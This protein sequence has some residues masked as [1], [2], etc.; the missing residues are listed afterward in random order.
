M[1]LVLGLLLPARPS[2]CD[3]EAPRW[4]ESAEVTLGPVERGHQTVSVRLSPGVTRSYDRLRIE[5]V[6]RQQFEWTDSAGKV[7]T[8]VHEPVRFAHER[9]TVR[10]TQDLDLHVSFR[11]PIDV[12]LLRERYG[13]ST[14]RPDVAVQVPRVRLLALEGGK[15][16]WAYDVPTSGGAHELDVPTPLRPGSPPA[17]GRTAL[18]QVNLD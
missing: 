17:G 15:T 7:R 18:G 3:E 9:E 2:R 13:T 6:Y 16:L 14:F 5:C 11:M 8:R 12:H 10:L 1:A 4:L